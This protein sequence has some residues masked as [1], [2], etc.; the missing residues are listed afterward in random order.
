VIVTERE[1]LIVLADDSTSETGRDDS[2][3]ANDH[4]WRLF[5]KQAQAKLKHGARPW[6]DQL[7]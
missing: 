4:R 6:E 3:A 2:S 1:G 7:P 5:D